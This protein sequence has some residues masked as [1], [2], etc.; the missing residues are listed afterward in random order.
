[1]VS[2]SVVRVG[3]VVELDVGG[4]LALVVIVAGVHLMERSGEGVPRVAVERLLDDSTVIG[5]MLQSLDTTT[6]QEDDGVA[7]SGSGD[8][9]IVRNRVSDVVDT[10][11]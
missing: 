11:T 9:R 3:G 4:R 5:Q 2:L 1:M 10:G 7:G 6:W 8:F